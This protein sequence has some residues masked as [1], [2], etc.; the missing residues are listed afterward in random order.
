LPPL[1]QAAQTRGLCTFLDRCPLR[2]D[3][4]CNSMPPP[5]QQLA[6]GGSI[7]CHH[8]EA[9]LRTAQTPLRVVEG[10]VA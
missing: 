8:T 5:R 9:D 10:D 1:R 2:V 4:V 7:L 6:D 3:G